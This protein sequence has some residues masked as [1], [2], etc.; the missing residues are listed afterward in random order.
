MQVDVF[1]S[2]HF[3]VAYFLDRLL[4]VLVAGESVVPFV[5]NRLSRQ[6]FLFYAVHLNNSFV[7]T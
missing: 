5:C 3:V 4:P 7:A 2:E 6:S 1:G